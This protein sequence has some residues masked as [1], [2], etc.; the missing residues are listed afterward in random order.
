M[1]S[2]RERKPEE[3]E[4]EPSRL[5]YWCF[6]IFIAA[7]IGYAGFYFCRMN[8]RW[9]P[10]PT[11]SSHSWLG[12]FAD[13][14]MLF[15]FGYFLG[16]FVGGSAADRFG[17]RRTL[18]FGGLLSALMTALLAL[19]PPVALILVLQILNGFGQGFGWPAVNKLL[20]VWL[21]RQNFA[22]AMAWWSTSYALG[23]FLATALATALSTADAIPIQTGL[24]L[25]L[26]APAGILLLTTCFFFRRTRELPADAGL[27]P[28]HPDVVRDEAGRDGA[29]GGWGAVLR[30]GEIQLL[31]LMYFFLK[32]TRYSL[33]FWLPVYLIDTQHATGGSALKLASVF[34]LLG[35]LGALASAYISDRLLDHRRYPVGATMLFLLAFVFPAAPSHQFERN[36]RHRHQHFD[37][38]DSDLRHRCPD[39]DDNCAGGC[40]YAA[41]RTG[42][43]IRE[44]RRLAGADA[45]AAADQHGHCLVWM[46]RHLQPVPGLLPDRRL[47]AGP[48]LEPDTN[49]R[50]PEARSRCFLNRTRSQPHSPHAHTTRPRRHTPR[51]SRAFRQC[52]RARLSAHSAFVKIA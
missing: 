2:I 22:V 30:N 15:G 48:A 35:F 31:A 40:T 47:A 16:Q 19:S 20:S 43:R 26:L 18:L 52:A 21:P 49:A 45:L 27:S 42:K 37:D 44:W 33:L 13:L 4:T 36:D 25:S 1:A 11:M 46:E 51:R 9:T 10:L 41:G 38:G 3:D 8:L 34:E 17:A 12:G 32:L 24:R 28:I 29:A 23:G 7:W 6:R 14:L 39:D 50:R 5:S